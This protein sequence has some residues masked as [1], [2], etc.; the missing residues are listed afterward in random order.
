MPL[1]GGRDRMGLQGKVY[2]LRN[3]PV[4]FA[5]KSGERRGAT[6]I[7]LRELAPH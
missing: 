1:T 7:H 6:L 3:F 5:K 2:A 4:I